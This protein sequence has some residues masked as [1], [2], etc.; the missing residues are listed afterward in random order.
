MCEKI[1]LLSE[2][3]MKFSIKQKVF[4]VGVYYTKLYKKVREEFLAK[5]GEILLILTIIV[6]DQVKIGINIAS[7]LCTPKNRSVIQIRMWC[8]MSRKRIVEPIFFTSTIT[9]AVYQDIIQ[10]FVSLL[11][12]S[13]RR[14]WL[15]QDNA[16]LQRIP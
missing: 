11:E 7:Q 3:K 12:K 4:I 8:G 5:Y 6:C 9:G 10:Q 1:F 14:G 15:Q 16:R 2:V 13:E